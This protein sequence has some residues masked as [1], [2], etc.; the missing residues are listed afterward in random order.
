[1]RRFCRANAFSTKY[2]NQCT[3]RDLRMRRYD[4]HLT[5]SVLPLRVDTSAGKED[6]RLARRPD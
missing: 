6:A 3:D 1:M 5:T 4:N 2:Q